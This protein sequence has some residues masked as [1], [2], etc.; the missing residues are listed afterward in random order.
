M[1][2]GASTYVVE[3][4]LDEDYLDRFVSAGFASLEI[5]AK[6]VFVDPDDAAQHV[7][8]REHMARTGLRVHSI[9]AGHQLRFTMSSPDPAIRAETVRQAREAARIVNALGGDVVVVHP[10]GSVRDVADMDAFVGRACEGAAEVV[11]AVSAEG[12]RVAFENANPNGFPSEPDMLMQI[13]GM[14]PREAVGVCID[15]G[16]MNC[17]RWGTDVIAAAAGRIV[18]THLHDN[19]GASDRHL[20]PGHG[21]I[22]WDHV[23]R[24]F[25]NAGYDGP[26]IF[27]CGEVGRP[28]FDEAAGSMQLLSDAWTRAASGPGP[29]KPD[30]I[31][32]SEPIS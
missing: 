23:M 16:H 20:P 1:E 25:R 17:T 2:F 13:V 4:R 24:A 19:D 9:H 12:A 14:F 15:T 7:R 6:P 10:G 21:N 8:L 30:G 22:D 11:R 31:S 32:G 27:E 28:P 26:W 29:S 18:S 3:K 5:G